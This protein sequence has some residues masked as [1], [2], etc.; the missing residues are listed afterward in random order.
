MFQVSSIIVNKFRG[1]I[2]ISN[3]LEL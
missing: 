3:G 1:L 2:V